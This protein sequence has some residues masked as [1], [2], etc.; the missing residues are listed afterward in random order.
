MVYASSDAH[1]AA[2]GL[3]ASAK[4]YSIPEAS[5]WSKLQLVVQALRVLWVFVLER[6]NVVISTGASCGYFAIR[7]GR[8]CRAKTIWVD[9][10]AN[11]DELSLTG[12]LAAK[13][14]DLVLT[15]WP[16]LQEEKPGQQ[17]V[18]FFGSVI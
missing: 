11:V 9:S 12:Q 7:L 16:S 13:H 18:E 10:I 5:R 1:Y 8:I 4:F 3:D 2:S 6:P 15:Q 14:C 17:R